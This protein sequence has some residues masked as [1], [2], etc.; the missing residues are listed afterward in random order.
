MQFCIGNDFSESKFV[1]GPART[2]TCFNVW[3]L[4]SN[5][6]AVKNWIEFR[7]H[8]GSCSMWFCQRT[9]I[10]YNERSLHNVFPFWE[11]FDEGLSASS[12]N[13]FGIAELCSFLLADCEGVGAHFRFNFAK[14]M[15]FSVNN[16]VFSADQSMRTCFKMWFLNPLKQS[17]QVLRG[18][19]RKV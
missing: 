6:F 7:E 9:T 16:F 5:I 8:N 3:Y 14:R 4:G 11:L 12:E 15:T 17:G 19:I 2:V 10:S 18:I 13:D 1:F